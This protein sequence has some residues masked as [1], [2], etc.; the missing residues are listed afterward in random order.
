MTTSKASAVASVHVVA[1]DLTAALSIFKKFMNKKDPG[2]A[3]L[4]FN[5][6]VLRIEMH[7]MAQNLPAS[8]S[9][10]QEARVSGRNLVRLT[11]LPKGDEDV[12]IAVAD[13]GCSLS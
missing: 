7:G 5:G 9:W 2:N 11:G 3:L 10:T 1:R 8:G 4:T 12:E 6:G 13:G